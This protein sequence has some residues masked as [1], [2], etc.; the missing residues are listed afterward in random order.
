MTTPKDFAAQH[1]PLLALELNTWADTGLLPDGKLRELGRML[2]TENPHDELQAAEH[3]AHRAIRDA[4]TLQAPEKR[5]P[6]QRYPEGIPWS[7]H[8]E[9][10]A[11]YCKRYGPQPALIEG[12][13]RGGFGISELDEFIPGWREKLSALKALREEIREMRDHIMAEAQRAGVLPPDIPALNLLVLRSTVTRLADATLRD[14]Q[15]RQAVDEALVSASGGLDCAVPEEDAA[16]ALNRLLKL[17]VQ[18]AQDP[19]VSGPPGEHALRKAFGAWA[20]TQ[21]N[22][23]IDLLDVLSPAEAERQFDEWKALLLVDATRYRALIDALMA[24]AQADDP[25][26]V[27]FVQRIQAA[28]GDD[29]EPNTIE[30]FNELVDIGRG[31]A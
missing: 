20:A 7:L 13:C 11:E 29:E 8:M 4:L 21:T 30:R 14:K 19:A 10:Y 1:A 24:A 28:L 22:G 6:V 2:R 3:L 26:D 27:E 5:A 16:A 12:W 23:E 25:T 15:W 31:A 9:A 18:Q 17:V